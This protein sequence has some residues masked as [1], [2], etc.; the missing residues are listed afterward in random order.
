MDFGVPQGIKEGETPKGVCAPLWGD[1]GWCPGV[2]PAL[3]H[4]PLPLR[5]EG[6]SPLLLFLARVPQIPTRFSRNVISPG[7]L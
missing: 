1:T 7:V 3:T 2:G 4:L 5:K 6:L